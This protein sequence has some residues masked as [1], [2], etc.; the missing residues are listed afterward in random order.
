MAFFIYLGCYA[1]LS[2]AAVNK[3]LSCCFQ[4]VVL[5]EQLRT[6]GI[7]GLFVHS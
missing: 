1:C 2:Q 4:A 3:V 7:P 5:E 6:V